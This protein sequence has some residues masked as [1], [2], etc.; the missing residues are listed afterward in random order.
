MYSIT[1][2][3]EKLKTGDVTLALLGLMTGR[4]AGWQIK[5]C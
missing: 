3:C 1:L 2:L 4:Q 5:Y